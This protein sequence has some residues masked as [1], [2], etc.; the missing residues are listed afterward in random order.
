MWPFKPPQKKVAIMVAKMYGVDPGGME[1]ITE[2]AE[3]LDELKPDDPRRSKVPADILE[4]DFYLVSVNREH[5]YVFRITEFELEIRLPF[6]IQLY[7][8][9]EVPHSHLYRSLP[10]P[11]V[12]A[13]GEQRAQKVIRNLVQDAVE[14]FRSHQRLCAN[15]FK[16]QPPPKFPGDPDVGI[17]G[18]PAEKY[19]ICK[20]CQAKAEAEKRKEAEEAAAAAAPGRR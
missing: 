8:G 9:V 19:V 15:C 6:T 2:I 17:L 5:G 1:F 10:V 12:L 16:A 13:L 11:A 18:L 3:W 4:G 7:T 20:T 14:T